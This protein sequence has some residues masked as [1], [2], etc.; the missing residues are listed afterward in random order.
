MKFGKFRVKRNSKILS[1]V[2]KL[3]SKDRLVTL[4]I[5]RIVFGRRRW[6]DICQK[7]VEYIP[8]QTGNTLKT[9]N[10]IRAVS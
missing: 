4:Q 2:C 8:Y 10:R 5:S 9:S 6:Y 1:F 3:C 7:C